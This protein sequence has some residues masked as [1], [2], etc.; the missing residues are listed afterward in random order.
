MFTRDRAEPIALP[1]DIPALLLI[2][3]IRDEAHRFAVTFHR[4]ARAMRDLRSELDDVPGIGAAAPQ[5]AADDVRQPRGRPAR[6]AR[7]VAGGRRRAGGRCGARLFLR[8]AGSDLRVGHA[9][10]IA[11]LLGAPTCLDSVPNRLPSS[12]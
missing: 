3:R 5:A 12:T 11:V 10:L 6:D 2:Q 7:G 9:G 8:R 4:R 1:R